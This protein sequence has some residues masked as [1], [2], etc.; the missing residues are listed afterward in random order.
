MEYTGSDV[1]LINSGTFRSDQIHKTGEFRLKDLGIIEF[2]SM[3]YV[4][5]LVYFNIGM[6]Q[7]G[8]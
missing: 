1:P 8:K 2:K 7:I 5:L 4:S 3:I 6:M